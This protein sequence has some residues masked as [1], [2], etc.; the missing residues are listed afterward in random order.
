MDHQYCQGGYCE[1]CYVM[2]EIPSL[3]VIT[4]K[5]YTSDD[6]DNFNEGEDEVI[7]PIIDST[8]YDGF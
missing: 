5:A 7:D 8:I 2:Y 1:G 6:S 4:D 3:K